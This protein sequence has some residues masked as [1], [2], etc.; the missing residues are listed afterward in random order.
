MQSITDD[1][2]D[3]EHGP[4]V[5]RPSARLGT[6]LEAARRRCQAPGDGSPRAFQP[7]SPRLPHYH[8]PSANPLTY[9][10]VTS[11]AAASGAACLVRRKGT[12]LVIYVRAPPQCPGYSDDALLA[13]FAEV[14]RVVLQVAPP[15]PECRPVFEPVPCPCPCSALLSRPLAL[16]TGL[17]HSAPTHP[18]GPTGFAFVFI[19][20]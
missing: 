10:K 12:V 17:Q 18:P 16:P 2:A 8:G 6:V 11:Y 3:P 20:G 9:P 5:A 1:D 13:E 14:D 4:P 19:W 7:G 15:P